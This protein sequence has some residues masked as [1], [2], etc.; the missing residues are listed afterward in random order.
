M[1]AAGSTAMVYPVGT[2]M[3][4]GNRMAGATALFPGDFVTTSGGALA[5]F[6]TPGAKISITSDTAVKLQPKAI[7]L[8]NGLVTVD[9]KAGYS[10]NAGSYTVV[11]SAGAGKYRVMRKDNE[12]IV[13]SLEGPLVVTWGSK[14]EVL[15]SGTT[16][17]A[18]ADPA[19]GGSQG[20]GAQPA[21]KKGGIIVI[22]A[23]S[24]AILGIGL[25]VLVSGSNPVAS[26]I[27]P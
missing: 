18:P 21:A 25:A 19:A 9:T 7:D 3:L 10:T 23:A 8:Q 17:A 24:A 4:N 12:V 6:A 22:G 11:P 27:R 2:V 13:A 16:W 20:G 1:W 5:S 26:P 14:S 15:K